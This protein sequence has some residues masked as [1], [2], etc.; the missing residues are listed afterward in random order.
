MLTYP[1]QPPNPTYVGDRWREMW[2]HRL[3]NAPELAYDWSAH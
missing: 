1:I 3:E 2:M